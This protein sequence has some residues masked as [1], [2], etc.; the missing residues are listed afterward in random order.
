METLARIFVIRTGVPLGYLFAF[1]FLFGITL[2]G[3]V[4]SVACLVIKRRRRLFLATGL[5]ACAFGSFVIGVNI[6]FDRVFTMMPSG[7]SGTVL[8]GEWSD[9]DATLRLKPDG[10]FDL[11]AGEQL[12]RKLR[13]T[14]ARGT[15]RFHP[16][17]NIVLNDDRNRKL[18][19]LAV[20]SFRGELRIIVNDFVD[21]DFWDGR[22]GFR[23]KP[24]SDRSGA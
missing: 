4:L 13:V 6:W 8:V 21:P 10:S 23:R 5:A 12:S 3:L 9:S 2:G 24:Y 11:V 22:L 19:D 7:L 20:V 1:L 18:P 17:A 15:W 14:E 16:F